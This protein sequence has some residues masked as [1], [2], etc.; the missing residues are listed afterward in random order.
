MPADKGI[1]Q[2]VSENGSEDWGDDGGP[3]IDA[4]RQ[5]PYAGEFDPHGNLI[6]RIG[7]HHRIRRMDSQTGIITLIAGTGEPKAIR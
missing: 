6:V 7:R 1:I 5:T 2:T 4:A 3:A